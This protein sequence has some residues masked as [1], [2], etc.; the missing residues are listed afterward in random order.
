MLGTSMPRTPVQTSWVAELGLMTQN[1]PAARVH[2]NV[3]G[4]SHKNLKIIGSI[5][6]E[7]SQAE[8]EG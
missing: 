2:M 3:S 8:K 1:V 6:Y 4:D 7:E 5:I